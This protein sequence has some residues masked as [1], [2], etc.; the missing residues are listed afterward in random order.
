MRRK[1]SRLRRVVVGTA[2]F[3]VLTTGLAMIVLPGPAF[4][5][6]PLGL[7]ILA[8]EFEW[9]GRVRDK[10]LAWI[11]RRKAGREDRGTKEE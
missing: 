7:A 9:A 8:T 3:A 4:L 5:L 10:A 1:H 2:G 11:K 6:I